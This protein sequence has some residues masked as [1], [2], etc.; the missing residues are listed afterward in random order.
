MS[1]KVYKKNVQKKLKGLTKVLFSRTAIIVLLM[2]LQ[3]GL[4]IAAFD[5]MKEKSVYFYGF[6]LGLTVI[7]VIAIINERSNPMIKLAWIVP[8]LVLPIF[9]VLFYLFIQMQLGTKMIAYRLSQLTNQTKPYLCQDETTFAELRQENPQIAN[10]VSYVSKKGGY[11]I[12]KNSEVTYFPIGEKK[13]EA[14][15]RELKKAEHF[16]FMEYFIV[17]EGYMWNTIRDILIEKASKGVE[18]RFMY[19]GMCSVTMLPYNYPK[20]LQQFGIKSKM[21]A[22]IRPVL[23]SSQNNR[24]HRKVVV[25]DG[26]V[27]FTGGINLADEYINKKVRFGHWKDTAVM[28]RGEAVRAFLMMFLQMWNITERTEENYERYLRYVEVAPP[29]PRDGFVMAY[30]DSPFDQENVG[31]EVYMNMIHRAE[32]YVHIMT[33]YLILDNEMLRALLFAAKSGVEVIIIMPHIPDKWYAFVLAKTY[34]EEL[35]EAGVQ[36]YEYTPGFVHAK[37]F[38]VDGDEAVVGTI[39]LDFRS[40]YLHF[41]DAAYMYQNSEISAIEEDY[42]KTL[43]KCQKITKEDCKNLPI[44]DR[45]AGRVLRLFAPLM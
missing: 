43:L 9:G 36:I 16:I 42:Q 45:I 18:V 31:E 17:E 37:V 13:F 11:P 24:D 39:N 3:I 20:K 22:P 30:G 23:S 10:L 44:K 32:R 19:D 5:W 7:T 27:A 14:L 6:F 28:V 40:L 25:I 4:I 21:F 35:I 41:E 12:Y 1:T 15:V 26:E 34:Y 38:V 8:V 33:P 2:L 29:C